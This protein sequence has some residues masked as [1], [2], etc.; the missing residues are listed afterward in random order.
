MNEKEDEYTPTPRERIKPTS[1]DPILC[2]ILAAIFGAIVVL[3]HQD[4][5]LLYLIY[6]LLVINL[7]RGIK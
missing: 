7:L 2:F 3:D 4:I 5:I 1:I 6:M